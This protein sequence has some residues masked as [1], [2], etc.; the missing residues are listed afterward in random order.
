MCTIVR[1]ALPKFTV[2]HCAVPPLVSAPEPNSQ[3]RSVRQSDGHNNAAMPRRL[4]SR[5]LASCNRLGST[6]VTTHHTPAPTI[7]AQAHHLTPAMTLGT[8]MTH[9]AVVSGL[10]GEQLAPLTTPAH[11]LP[12]RTRSAPSEDPRTSKRAMAP[13]RATAPTTIGSRCHR[14]GSSCGRP[15]QAT[16]H[17]PPRD[18][19]VQVWESQPSDMTASSAAGQIRPRALSLQLR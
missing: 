16:N 14:R 7:K 5:T 9:R 2:G 6:D 19:P 18:R 17:M 15:H 8:G 13:R 4:T 10:P 1:G 12:R 11:F 3:P